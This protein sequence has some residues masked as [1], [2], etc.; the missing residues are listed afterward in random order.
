MRRP[1]TALALTALVAALPAT[2]SATEAAPVAGAAKKA[3]KKK[4]I[5]Y[6]GKTSGGHKVTFR[7]RKGK[8]YEFMAGIGITCLPIQG[9]GKPSTYV[10]LWD[11]RGW[12]IKQNIKNA[13][14]KYEGPVAGYYNPVTKTHHITSKRK[15]N[16]K[17]G[18][19]LRMQ[20]S[21]LIPKYPIGTF[22]IY[23][24]LGH[25]KF[26]AKPIKKRR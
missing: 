9:G 12:W 2:A 21:F 10:D 23:S 5:L 24:C 3:K 22:A 25:T 4:G 20:Y 16:G 1:L 14:I 7:L 8:M 15:R 17:I 19:K 11:A 18:G 13:K 6:K 26:S